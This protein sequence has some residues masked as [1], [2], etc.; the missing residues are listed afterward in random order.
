MKLTSPLRHAQLVA[1]ILSMSV[2]CA[3]VVAAKERPARDGEGRGAGRDVIELGS[4]EFESTAKVPAAA[5]GNVYMH[6][7][8]TVRTSRDV[9]KK[10]NEGIA[11]GRYRAPFKDNKEF[12]DLVV[13]S[14][15]GA[16]EIEFLGLNK[17]SRFYYF[18]EE[19]LKKV[20][21]DPGIPRE[22]SRRT[23]DLARNAKA[24]LYQTIKPNDFEGSKIIYEQGLEG[25]CIA[26]VGST[27][28]GNPPVGKLTFNAKEQPIYT[29]MKKVLSEDK[30]SQRATPVIEKGDFDDIIKSAQKKKI[31]TSKD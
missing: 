4:A 8:I 15:P 10:I 13:G 26:F 30:P 20:R 27:K 3:L 14:R 5:G 25:G 19:E 22:L 18:F 23:S 1:A 7:R 16:F 12:M 28:R 6:V 9:V 29:A 11:S 17:E 24:L 21:T 31:L 2:G